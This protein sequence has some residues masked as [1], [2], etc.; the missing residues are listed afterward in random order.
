MSAKKGIN[1][2]QMDIGPQRLLLSLEAD[3][4]KDNN[5][6]RQTEKQTNKQN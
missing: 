4:Q 6:N 5:T 2:Q 1:E 3:R